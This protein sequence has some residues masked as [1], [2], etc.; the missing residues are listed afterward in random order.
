M[1]PLQLAKP[2]IKIYSRDVRVLCYESYFSVCANSLNAAY[3]VEGSSHNDIC[4][5]FL[6]IMPYA[7]FASCI[8]FFA[9]E[10]YLSYLLRANRVHLPNGGTGLMT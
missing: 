1:L 7:H 6:N 5:H 8:L 4:V 2:P 3:V 9:S 10:I